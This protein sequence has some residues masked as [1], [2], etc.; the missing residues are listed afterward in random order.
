MTTSVTEMCNDVYRISTCAPDYGIQFNQFL[1]T[2][3]EPFLMHTGF[4]K[5]FAGTRDAVAAVLDP[6][7]L[8][9]I[10]F[11]H[12]ESDECGALN[13]WLAT[14]P[15]A[16]AVCSFVGATVSVNDFAI[17]PARALAD[18]EVLPI[19]RR[20]LRFPATPHVP[21]GW[22]AG[23]FFEGDR[24]H[25]VV[26]RPLLPT[27]RTRTTDACGPGWSRTRRHHRGAVGAVGE[28]HAVH[29]VHG[30]HLAAP[31]RPQAADP[32]GD[33]RLVVFRR[34]RACTA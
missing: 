32:R 20:R 25:A 30:R 29:A 27:R 5:M 14:A 10:G 22:D 13:E 3:D 9:W 18:D 1:V 31:R 2:D 34:R 28:G 24:A 12:F 6:A 23:L 11:S 4:K 8:R 21:H 15:Q 33:A 26:L 17:R 19:G 16:Q 7:R